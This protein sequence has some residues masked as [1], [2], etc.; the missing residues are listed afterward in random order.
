[1][2]GKHTFKFG[3]NYRRYDVSDHNFFFNN[4]AVYFGYNTAGMQNFVNGI[5]YQYRESKNVAADVPV[6]L[7]G[8][9]AYAHDDWKI[10]SIFTVTLGFRVEH[11][12]NPVC[13]TNCFGQ[14]LI[15]PSSSARQRNQQ[16]LRPRSPIAPT[17]NTVSTGPIRSVDLINLAAERRV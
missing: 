2:K 7:W 17:L 15:V 13:Q 14:T 3:E 5:A 1:M 8:M 10:A 4:P 9:G 12:S 6:A 16:D 11:N